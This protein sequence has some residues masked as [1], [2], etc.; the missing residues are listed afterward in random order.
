MP[1]NVKIQKAD[2]GYIVT[3]G[4][5]T[6]VG[7]DWATVASEIRR[8]FDHP[9]KVEEEYMRKYRKNESSFAARW[10]AHEKQRSSRQ[11]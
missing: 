11:Q 3:V 7:S 1:N 6:L 4:C 2:N 5:M 10:R 8:Y 9:E